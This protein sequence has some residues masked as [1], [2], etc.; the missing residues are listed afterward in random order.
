[1]A[2]IFLV[3][4]V[5][6]VLVGVGF[7]IANKKNDSPNEL[8]WKKCILPG[9]LVYF[10]SLVL[11]SLSTSIFQNINNTD[12]IDEFLVNVFTQTFGL[13]FY[14]IFFSFFL[15]L[16]TLILG[17]KF[18][19]K[20]NLENVQKLISFVGLSFVLVL[21]LNAIMTGFFSNADFMIFLAG[22]SF[23]GIATPWFF[24]WRVFRELQH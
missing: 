18:L 3:S 4:V 22:F 6:A 11:G 20:T 14:A 10:I 7:L 24:G 16:P 12:T 2:Y 21:I 8:S 17:L 13:L 23:F 5:I 19:S 15:V 1:M 9:L